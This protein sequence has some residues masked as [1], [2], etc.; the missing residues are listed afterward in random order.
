[1][2]PI[3]RRINSPK[4]EVASSEENGA[5]SSFKT[6]KPKHVQKFQVPL[7]LTESKR[8]PFLAFG[9]IAYVSALRDLPRLAGCP[10]FL[11]A[12][13][14]VDNAKPSSPRASHR[15]ARIPSDCSTP[16]SAPHFVRVRQCADRSHPWTFLF[17]PTWPESVHSERQLSVGDPGWLIGSKSPPRSEGSGLSLF[18]AR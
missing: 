10:V 7:W 8:E 9:W 17:A 13:T 6:R 4:K 12:L 18:S 2:N 16:V 14:L 1:M 3:F 15:R 11:V 5:E